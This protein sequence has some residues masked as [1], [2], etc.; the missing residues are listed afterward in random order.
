MWQHVWSRVLCMELGREHFALVSLETWISSVWERGDRLCAAKQRENSGWLGWCEESLPRGWAEGV[1]G[2]GNGS[3]ARSQLWTALL[4]S[5]P[6]RAL[7][8]NVKEHPHHLKPFLKWLLI[9]LNYVFFPCT[10]MFKCERKWWEWLLKMLDSAYLLGS[11][12][13]YQANV[14]ANTCNLH[15]L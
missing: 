12:F 5:A 3:R 6:E 10:H 7:L 2:E 13:S 8:E 9:W 14:S 4:S 11:I 1:Q 15:C